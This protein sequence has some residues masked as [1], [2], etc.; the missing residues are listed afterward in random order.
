MPLDIGLLTELAAMYK[1]GILTKEEFEQAK[2]E[3]IGQPVSTVEFDFKMADTDGDGVV[4]PEELAAYAAK[5]KKGSETTD[6]RNPQCWSCWARQ[7]R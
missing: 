4:S 1:D 2:G 7:S 3:L 6:P 5:I